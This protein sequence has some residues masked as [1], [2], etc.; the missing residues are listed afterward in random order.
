MVRKTPTLPGGR[1]GGQDRKP[2]VNLEGIRADNLTPVVLGKKEGEFGLA[3]PCGA[4]DDDGFR[5][6]HGNKKLTR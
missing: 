1:L 6:Y 4:G 3:G 2:R 5:G